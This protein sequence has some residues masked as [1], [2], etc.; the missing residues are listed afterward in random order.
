MF[1]LALPFPLT[2]TDTQ[3]QAITMILSKPLRSCRNPGYMSHVGPQCRKF[4]KQSW[5][6]VERRITSFQCLY[7]DIPAGVYVPV[8][9]S[10]AISCKGFPF[11]DLSKTEQVWSKCAQV[12]F[13]LAL[14]TRPQHQ[15]VRMAKEI[16]TW[17][18]PWWRSSLLL[19][20]PVDVEQEYFRLRSSACHVLQVNSASPS[21]RPALREEMILRLATISRHTTKIS[22][23]LSSVALA[24]DQCPHVLVV[25]Q[26]FKFLEKLRRRIYMQHVK[27]K[28]LKMD[29]SFISSDVFKHL[30]RSFIES[31]NPL[32]P[33][34]LAAAF[35][36][37]L[38]QMLTQ[39]PKDPDGNASNW[40][41]MIGLIGLI[42]PAS[43]S[44]IQ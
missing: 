5:G 8:S 9:W 35:F 14:S 24:A 43:P 34:A 33:L 28:K 11:E 20:A 23:I 29:L 2:N 4:T 41:W 7:C 42:S 30:H 22:K 38:Y 44:F 12:V 16:F 31:R 32:K 6:N 1:R 3:I 17:V 36:A 13:F 39:A 27:C 40:C 37:T 19:E 10:A 26:N 18:L 15:H 21:L 25:A